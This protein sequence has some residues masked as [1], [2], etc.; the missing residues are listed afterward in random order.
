MK[1]TLKLTFPNGV[2]V[3]LYNSARYVDMIYLSCGEYFST[4]IRTGNEEDSYVE[5]NAGDTLA[6]FRIWLEYRSFIDKEEMIEL[7][8]NKSYALAGLVLL[9][10]M[11]EE[12][13]NAIDPFISE[14]R[15]EDED[16]S[17]VLSILTYDEYVRE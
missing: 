5:A 10:W 13:D 8:L 17:T 1:E 7:L 12:L 9:S 16:W 14:V 6:A 2:L 4:Y 11:R 15:L 3:D